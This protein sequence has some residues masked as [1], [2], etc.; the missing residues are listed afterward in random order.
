MITVHEIIME[1]IHREG[2]YVNH[3]NDKGGPTKYG[4]TQRTLS[5][6]Y[7]RQ[8]TIDDVKNLDIEQAEEI[9]FRRYFVGPRLD[10]LPTSLHAILVDTAVLFG[11]RDAVE[12][13]Q[14]ICNQAGFGPL[15]E[16]GI[17]GPNTRRTIKSAVDEM[18]DFFI[19]AIVEERIT[20]HRHRVEEKPS[21]IVFLDGW[22]N[23][24]EE[25]RVE[26]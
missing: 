10:T 5:A 22:I 20:Y 3:P 26:V 11:P 14:S 19:N 21:Q 17:V 8:A 23:R 15:N 18:G 7:G 13:A 4:V 25:F 9:F 24:A 2:G 12:F 1:V 16:D 6:Y